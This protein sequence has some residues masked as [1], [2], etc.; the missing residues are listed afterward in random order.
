MK[1]LQKSLLA[2]FHSIREHVYRLEDE[3]SKKEVII[4][5][6]NDTLKNFTGTVA[7]NIRELLDY[8]MSSFRYDLDPLIDY[9]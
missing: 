6:A 7:L 8:S 1:L 3:N 9:L 4:D 5:A 2:K